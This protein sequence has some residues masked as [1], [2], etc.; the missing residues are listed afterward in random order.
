MGLLDGTYK[1]RYYVKYQWAAP[2][3]SGVLWPG[4]K[5]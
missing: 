5:L 4:M 2:L 3:K 1:N